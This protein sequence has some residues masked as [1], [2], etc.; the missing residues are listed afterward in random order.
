LNF[1]EF[2]LYKESLDIEQPPTS[3]EMRNALKLL[4]RGAQHRSNDFRKHFDSEQ[5]INEL[6]RKKSRHQQ[7][8]NFLSY[9]YNSYALKDNIQ[10]VNIR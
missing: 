6:F 8:I 5:F 1:R 9:A 7:L 3:A 10:Y 4:K 2:S